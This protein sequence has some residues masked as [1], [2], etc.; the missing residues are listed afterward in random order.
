MLAALGLRCFGGLSLGV[1]SGDC[2]L[3]LVLRLLIVMASLAVDGAQAPELAG[4]SSLD[5]WVS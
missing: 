4:F 1:T 5:T 3:V 2:S